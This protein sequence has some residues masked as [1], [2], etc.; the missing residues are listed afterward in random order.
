MSHVEP[1]IPG[2]RD[3]TLFTPGPLTT[4]LSVKQAMLHDPGSWHHEF[5]DLVRNVRARLLAFA[6][7]APGIFE[8]ILMQGS[9]TFGV[10][11]VF[12]TVIPPD[13]RIC[14]VANGAYG[15]R[16]IQMAACLRIPVTAL[17]VPENRLPDPEQLRAL[18]AADPS[19]SHVAVV[20]CET[21]TG[22]LNPIEA[23]G[24]VVKQAGRVYI[25]DAM[26]SFGAVPIDFTAAGIDFLISS[27]NK[28]F[29][30]VPG[31]SFII[32][33][34][35]LL[36]ASEGWARCLSLDL[37]AQL[38]GFEKNGQFR[39]TPPTHTILAFH[40]A[41]LE[42]E[43]EGGLAARGARYAANHRTL[44]AGMVRLGFKVYLD[45]AV[46]SF[47]ITSFHFPSD[48]AFTF[49]E[50]YAR[51]SARGFIIYPGKISQ[52]DTFRIGSIGRIFEADIRALLSAIEDAR[53]EMGFA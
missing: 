9:G 1:S 41:L 16:M 27:P 51:L 42:L 46:Q 33:R 25:V 43:Q 38:K 26:S 24:R 7:V 36:L 18:L 23:L 5:N 44:V 22:I 12:S 50:F 3:K 2:A 15:E 48:P 8:A 6:G 39:Y 47:I 40:Q 30:G 29:E 20:H 17:R 35:D 21:T 49:G 19:I 32:G 28:C 4:S 34:R 53:R 31:F 52:A 37:L 14:V 45:P 11:A 10:E 13:G